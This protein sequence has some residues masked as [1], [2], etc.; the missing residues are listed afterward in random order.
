MSRRRPHQTRF[1][2]TSIGPRKSWAGSS[3]WYTDN[4]RP[5][6]VRFASNSLDTGRPRVQIPPGPP[7]QRLISYGTSGDHGTPA[8]IEKNLTRRKSKKTVPSSDLSGLHDH[9]T[10]DPPQ[11]TFNDNRLDLLQC[12][13]SSVHGLM[14]KESEPPVSN[15]LWDTN[16]PLMLALVIR[17]RFT[18]H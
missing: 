14:I 18:E 2:P 5:K 13:C 17:P 8:E 1:N 12:Q 4:V 15:T 6:N 7:R 16:V 3:A 9:L 10:Y 11:T